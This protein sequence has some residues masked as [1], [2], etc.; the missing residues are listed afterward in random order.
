MFSHLQIYDPRERWV[1][2]GA[3]AVLDALAFAGRLLGSRPAA[4]EPKRILLL[5]LERVGDLVMTLDAIAAVRQQ[6][7]TAE[8]HLVVGSWNEDLARLIPDVDHLETLDLPWLARETGGRSV[9]ALLACAR[10]W[11]ATRYD[12]VINFE[13]DLRTNLLVGL[14]GA[15]R[16]AGFD[17][18]GGGACLTIRTPY[19]PH[20]HNAENAL[21]LVAHAFG[22]PT[23]SLPADSRVL[24]P[25]LAVPAAER[26]RATRLLAS[27]SAPAGNLAR[28]GPLVG[29]HA[30]GGRR[31]KQWDPDRF[32]SVAN[33]LAESHGAAIVLTGSE[34]DR[35]TVAEV[36]SAM[37]PD[38]TTIDLVGRVGL[39]P[40]AAV[41][42]RLDLF[43]TNDTGPMHLAAEMRVP[44]VAIFGPSTPARYAP[45]NDRTRVVRIDLPCSPCNRIRRPPAR[46]VGRT[47]DC[48]TGIDEDMVYETAIE[49]IERCLHEH[50]GQSASNA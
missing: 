8:I 17:M 34:L 25:R 14:S 21:R 27:S 19:D 43:I 15:P 28:K 38:V 50:P 23:A 32:A 20:M 30:G 48:L 1:V 41:L 7:P 36:R 24:R 39:V 42:Q 45:R 40:L 13:G 11:R 5:R 26:E 44:V 35:P 22:R 12:L 3:D 31:V 46:C 4:I 16:R 47:P 33:R 37:A 2:G 9:A 18:A 6:A 29:L 49:L 10:R